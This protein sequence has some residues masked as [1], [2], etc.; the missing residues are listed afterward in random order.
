M[1]HRLDL[2]ASGEDSGQPNPSH[3]D[4]SDLDWMVPISAL[5]ERVSVDL[6]HLFSLRSKG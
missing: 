3:L 5:T 6:A 4:L 2:V 1:R